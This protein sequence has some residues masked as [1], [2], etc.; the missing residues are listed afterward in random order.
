MHW[1]KKEWK[2]DNKNKCYFGIFIVNN[3][4]KKIYK[5]RKNIR[6]NKLNYIHNETLNKIF[7]LMNIKKL[8]ARK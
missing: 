8:K 6:R 7:L 2:H 5:K 3:V 4:N 1:V